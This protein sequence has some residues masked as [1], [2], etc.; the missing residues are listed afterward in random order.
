MRSWKIGI[1][2]YLAGSLLLL[3]AFLMAPE[4]TAQVIR[5]GLFHDEVVRSVA[6]S[7]TGGEYMVMNGEN[8]IGEFREGEILFVTLKEDSVT[9][10][11]PE[12][13]FGTFDRIELKSLNIYSTFR[14]RPV[15]PA[16]DSRSF[17]DDLLLS[18]GSDYLEIINQV[19]FD[20]YIAGVLEAEVGPN[21]EDELYKAHALLIRTYMLNHFDRHREEGFSL[22]DG[23]H[24]Q[25]YHGRVKYNPGIAK[26]VF[27]TSGEVVTDFHYKLITA[28]YHAN[29]GGETQRASDV[30]LKD[31]D[32]LQ[33]VIDPYSLHQP[34]AKWYDTIYF[35][36]WKKYLLE[37]GL[38]SVKKMPEEVLYIQQRHRRKYFVLDTDSLLMTTIREDWGLRST[39][40]NMFPEE[41]GK[42]VIWGKGYGHGVGLSQE[43]A[44]YMATQGFN[45]KDILRFYFFNIRIMHYEDLPRSSLPDLEYLNNR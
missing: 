21:A 26:S 3:N 12:R 5:I 33:A 32:Y 25:A 37:K 15:T 4:A 27:E 7:C 38:K 35:D 20:K 18:S 13:V 16:L 1:I 34:A 28:V 6:V 10:H 30:W 17:D 31:Y 11:S 23:V 42:I 45:Y 40:F 2:R 43:G 9:L 19:D 44:M 14:L 8:R 41:G 39:F 22:C 36:D 24:C 29:S